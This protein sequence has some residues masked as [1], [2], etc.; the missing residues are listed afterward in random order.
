MLILDHAPVTSVP[1]TSQVE[2][3]TAAGTVIAA[4]VFAMTITSIWVTTGITVVVAY[5]DTPVIWAQK[6]RVVL[7]NNA[8]I[9]AV[10]TVGGTG[11]AITLTKTIPAANDASLNIGIDPLGLSVV[12]V[13]SAP[14]SANTTAGVATTGDVATQPGQFALVNG[15]DLYMAKTAAP[16]PTTWS[17]KITPSDISG[18]VPKTT[19]VNSK[20]LSANITLAASDVGA[21]TAAQGSK[22]DSALQAIADKSITLAKQADMATASVVYRK[23]AGAGP[24]E[25]QTLDTLKTDL[26]LNNVAN[27]SEAQ[28]VASG[29]VAD[30]I[31]NSLA[32]FTASASLSSDTTITPAHSGIALTVGTGVNITVPVP[33]TSDFN[34]FAIS[35][36]GSCNILGGNVFDGAGTLITAITAEMGVCSIEPLNGANW[37]LTS[38]VAKAVNFGASTQAVN[39][40]IVAGVATFAFG[41]DAAPAFRAAVGLGM[42]TY[43]GPL[44]AGD[45]TGNAR[46]GAAVDIQAYRFSAA[47]VASGNYSTAV[48][49]GNTASNEFTTSVGYVNIASGDF[50]SSAFGY[51]NQA[52]ANGT[53]AFGSQNI[54]SGVNSTAVGYGSNATGGTSTA[55]G[56]VNHATGACSTAIGIGNTASGTNS[57]ALGHNNN[58]VNVSCLTLGDGNTA[59]SPAVG[60]F[61][62][63]QHAT[64]VGYGNTASGDGS[65]ALGY[66]MQAT[67]GYSIA[68]GSY[69]HASGYYSIVIGYFNTASGLGSSAIGYQVQTTVSATQEIGYWPNLTTRGGAVRIHGA[70][71]MVASTLQNRSVAYIDGG[72]TRGSEADNT[73]MRESYSIRRNGD[74]ILIDI[75]EGGVIKT[76]TLGTAV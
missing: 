69:G 46:G 75:N 55:V 16:A 71:G 32:K 66:D 38:C 19:T 9:A 49:T 67:S 24:P 27:K 18:L 31:H 43:T 58:S 74:V 8:A 25:V 22:A 15:V 61:S 1:G 48:G 53:S 14:T 2:T 40:S 26:N 30:A 35:C 56:C 3:A 41:S 13:T 76:L 4:G 50:G 20:P 36:T 44:I 11:P 64:S 7:S 62:G 28:L 33:S 37:L 68:L 29:A 51:L 39:M 63:A 57:A 45:L 54:A 47:A 65:I 17:P 6:T 72:S 42:I 5:G 70:T 73:L 23:T 10:F 59:G 52:T 34:R 12:G 21:A 60:S